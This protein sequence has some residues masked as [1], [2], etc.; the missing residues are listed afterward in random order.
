MNRE[1]RRWHQFHDNKKRGDT[2]RNSQHKMRVHAG[3]KKS[4]VK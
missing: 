3:M 2:N 4:L 1:E